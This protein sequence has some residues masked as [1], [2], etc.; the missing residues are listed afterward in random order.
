VKVGTV[1]ELD[2]VLARIEDH[3]GAVYVEVLIPEE[4]SQP[5][6]AN[7]IDLDYKLVV[8]TID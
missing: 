3:D 4:E 1:A 7:V 6:P 2:D 5:L 8:P